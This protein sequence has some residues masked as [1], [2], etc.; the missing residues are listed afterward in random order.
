MW[1]IN[2]QILSK[3]KLYVKYPMVSWLKVIGE[4]LLKKV[5]LLCFYTQPPSISQASEFC[6]TSLLGGHFS[7]R[8]RY[9][10][11][12]CT[13]TLMNCWFIE[14]YNLMCFKVK[15][16]WCC[17]I[18]SFCNDH[19]QCKVLP[20]QKIDLLYIST[21]PAYISQAANLWQCNIQLPM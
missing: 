12:L 13:F 7:Y 19:H 11:Q 10:E 16:S 1:F 9:H 4:V 5:A 14:F 3:D 15:A 8:T 21:Q 17:V 20:W 18:S 6:M 2:A